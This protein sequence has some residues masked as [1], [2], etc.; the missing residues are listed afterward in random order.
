V[1]RLAISQSN[2]IPWKGYFDMIARVDEFVLFDDMQFTRRDWRNRNQIKTAQ[3]LHWLTIPVQS[4]GNYFE[5]IKN[6][7]VSEPGWAA[8]HWKTIRL[9]YAKAPYFAD[10]APQ[11]E[12]WYEQAG[13]LELLSAVNHLFI[14]G[15]CG[16]LG[17]ET[18]LS[19]SMDYQIVDGKNERLI[20]I[21]QEAGATN[22]LS[23]PAA[24]DYVDEPVFQQAGVQ[25]EWM[26]Y[27]RYPV[28]EQRHGE[29]AHGVSVL[30][31]IFNC[32]PAAP[33]FVWR[34]QA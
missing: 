27:S 17:I 31:V 22:Y 16:V 10:Y 26:D 9:N 4:K 18:K 7:R 29:F 28:Y 20:S 21:C 24:K 2:Y 32:G 23:G 1:K 3:G 14:Q 13:K 19:W 12:A 34:Y 5:P 25:V 6:I 8:Q 15:I 11:V 30:D 33:D